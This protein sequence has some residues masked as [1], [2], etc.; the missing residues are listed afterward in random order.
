MPQNTFDNNQQ[1]AWCHHATLASISCNDSKE[2]CATYCMKWIFSIHC[3]Y[4][5]FRSYQSCASADF[6][7]PHNVRLSAGTVLAEKKWTCVSGLQW[8]CITSVDRMTQFELP[9]EIHKISQHFEWWFRLIGFPKTE[10]KLNILWVI[11]VNR[12]NKYFQMISFLGD[13]MHI[14]EW[15]IWTKLAYSSQ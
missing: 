12:L 10:L 15:F 3:C 14:Y 8:I 4:W 13:M 2:H 9:D 7:A 6:V 1:L 5:R 11:L